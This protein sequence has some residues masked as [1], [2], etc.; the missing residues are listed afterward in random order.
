MGHR[1][2]HCLGTFSFI[3]QLPECIT[4]AQL[5]CAKDNQAEQGVVIVTIDPNRIG[6][7]R[8]HPSAAA[9]AVAAVAARSHILTM[10]FLG[11]AGKVLIWALKFSLWRAGCDVHERLLFRSRDVS[12]RGAQRD[13]R[14]N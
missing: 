11:N 6:Q 12:D 13:D 10:T 5:P 8:S 4:W 2:H 14:K 7:W 3:A 9:A 1:P